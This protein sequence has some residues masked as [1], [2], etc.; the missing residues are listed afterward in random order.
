MKTV[1]Y[2]AVFIIYILF[3][4]SAMLL[5]YLALKDTFAFTSFSDLP[6]QNFSN[7][8]I[9]L[10]N[11]SRTLIQTF[12]IF[13]PANIIIR[14]IILILRKLIKFQSIPETVHLVSAL[15]APLMV[16][17]ISQEL[18]NSINYSAYIFKKVILTDGFAFNTTLYSVLSALILISLNLII[19]KFREKD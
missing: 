10:S 18:V 13:L 5:I 8:E 19:R 17:L 2:L 6:T 15:F 7:N 3:Y 11:I 14:T 1:K 12:T 16:I 9:L 4:S